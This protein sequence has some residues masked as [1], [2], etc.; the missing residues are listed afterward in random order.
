MPIQ[1]EENCNLLQKPPVQ[2]LQRQEPA[3]RNLK[4]STP[5]LG[6][7]RG[8][9]AL[10]SW[11]S[12]GFTSSVPPSGHLYLLTAPFCFLPA[13]IVSCITP[14]QQPLALLSCSLPGLSKW[15]AQVLIVLVKS[16]I[17][18]ELS[19]SHMISP[20]KRW[21]FKHRILPNMRFFRKICIMLQ[22]KCYI[23]LNTF[24]SYSVLGSVLE[25]RDKIGEQN[26]EIIP[27]VMEGIACWK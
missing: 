11:L 14:P 23:Q 25:A 26:I 13:G 12:A 1:Q 24:N 2:P 16:L 27:A 22:Q 18:F 5:S 6:S 20:H 15:L 9:P 7:M 21:Y 3:L 17:T 8:T 4:L 19:V 10:L